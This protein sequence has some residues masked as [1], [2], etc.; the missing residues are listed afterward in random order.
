LASKGEKTKLWPLIKFGAQKFPKLLLFVLITFALLAPV[1]VLMMMGAIAGNTLIFVLGLLV[2]I[3][4]GIT[5]TLFLFYTT[6]FINLRNE[7][8]LS[9]MSKSVDLF[10]KHWVTTVVGF[11]V[12]M[13]LTMVYMMAM[14]LAVVVLIIPVAIFVGLAA[15]LSKLL[16]LVLGAIAVII[17][18]VAAMGVGAGFTTFMFSFY[19]ELFNRLE[20]AK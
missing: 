17:L 14:I 16:A 8:V 4:W 10:K 7:K 15:V 20:S 11:F 5:I 6:Y 12:V 1:I 2:T 13:G 9:A 18:F 3:V 19:V